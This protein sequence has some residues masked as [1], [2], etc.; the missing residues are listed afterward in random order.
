MRY[1]L[2]AALI[3]CLHAGV[4]WADAD[5]GRA[6]YMDNC[7]ICHGTGGRGDGLFGELLQLTI[8]DLTT[9]SLRNGGRFPTERVQ[10]VIDGREEVRAHG[11]REMPIWGRYFSH[12]NPLTGDAARPEQELSARSRILAVIDYLHRLQVGR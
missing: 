3:A 7:A 6:E 8:P 12:Q 11:S 2:A 4:S 9:L 1:R 5:A 10:A